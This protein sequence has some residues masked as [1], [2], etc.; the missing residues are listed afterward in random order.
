MYSTEIVP[1]NVPVIA[2]LA[3]V[4]VKVTSDVPTLAKRAAA[5]V[6]VVGT[7]EITPPAVVAVI[8][9][10]VVAPIA[11]VITPAVNAEGAVV[12]NNLMFEIKEPAGITTLVAVVDETPIPYVVTVV[13]AA[14]FE[15]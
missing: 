6:F 3:H 13:L 7:N 15:N 8:V 11:T 9:P 2:V 12:S 1:D 14:T 4:N 5:V 10:T